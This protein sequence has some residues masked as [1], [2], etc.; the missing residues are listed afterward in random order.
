MEIFNKEALKV[1][2]MMENL[3]GYFF[4]ND[5]VRDY[6]IR[7]YGYDECDDPTYMTLRYIED[8]FFG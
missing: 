5:D 3:A 4:D 6:F 7:H 2:D 8:V 1:V